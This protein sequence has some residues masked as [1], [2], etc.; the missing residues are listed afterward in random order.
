MIINNKYY[1]IVKTGIDDYKLTIK[2]TK[3]EIDFKRDVNFM[4]KIQSC[5]AKGRILMIKQLKES[6]LTK[7]D[8]IERKE[9]TDENGKVV[10]IYDDSMFRYMEKECIKDATGQVMLDLM[11]DTLGEEIDSI[12]SEM[13]IDPA[14]EK[15]FAKR[16]GEDFSNCMLN[17]VDDE[18]TPRTV[19]RK[20]ATKQ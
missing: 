4:K 6:G 11:N 3:R 12:V 13:N 7:D 15:D 8:L 14:E 17:R 5:N 16:F 10:V 20:K 18:E 1:S 9:T 2:A 19:A